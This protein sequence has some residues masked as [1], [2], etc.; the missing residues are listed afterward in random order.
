MQAT[1]IGKLGSVMAVCL[2]IAAPQAAFAG[3]TF[4]GIDGGS[5]DLDDYRGHPVLVVNT[6]SLC[7]YAGQ[8]DGLQ[9][10]HDRYGAAGLLVLAVPSDDFAQEL[11]TGKEVKA[12]CALNFDLTLPMTDITHVRGPEAHPFYE[13]LRAQHGFEPKWN[14][15][16]VL[17][18]PDGALVATWGSATNPLS[19]RVTDQI[20]RLLE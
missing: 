15:N 5:I 17:I 10:L 4:A 14:F 1:W 20:D 9:V 11:A 6:A 19:A 2:S 3:Y 13:W 16:K 8:Y 7:A 18:G 12:F